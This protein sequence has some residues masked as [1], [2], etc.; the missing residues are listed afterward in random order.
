[1]KNFAMIVNDFYP[2][3]I[4]ATFSILE[5]FWKPCYASAYDQVNRENWKDVK[6]RE[7]DVWKSIILPDFFWKCF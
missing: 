7:W 1:M 5:V 2:L 4:A 3:T 6:Q